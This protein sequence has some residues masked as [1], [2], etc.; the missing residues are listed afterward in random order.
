MNWKE[1]LIESI[2]ISQQAEKLLPLSAVERDRSP[3]PNNSKR[4]AVRLV[5]R[6]R[7]SSQSNNKL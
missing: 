3:Q 1:E 2:K 5:V 6:H 7:S 4:V